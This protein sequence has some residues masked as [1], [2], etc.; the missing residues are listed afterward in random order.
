MDRAPGLVL[1]LV[2]IGLGIFAI[3]T[4]ASAFIGAT[5]RGPNLPISGW[6]AVATGFAFFAA[7]V[8]ALF[9]ICLP[10]RMNQS[11]ARRQGIT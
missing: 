5:R 6:P 3:G 8:A 1:V 4:E 11:P 10:E 2:L 9:G 7:A